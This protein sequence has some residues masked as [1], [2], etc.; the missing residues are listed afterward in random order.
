MRNICKNNIGYKD[1][2]F[3]VYILSSMEI[4]AK[5]LIKDSNPL[6]NKRRNSNQNDQ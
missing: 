1:N 3:L 5:L 6:N 4:I 2:P